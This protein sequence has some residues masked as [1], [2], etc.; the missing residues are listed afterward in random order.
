MTLNMPIL[1][2]RALQSDLR[3]DG[4]ALSLARN[5]PVP[6]RQVSVPGGHGVFIAPCPPTLDALCSDPPD[7]DRVA[8]HDS[9]GDEVVNFF[10]S[11]L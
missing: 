11:N 8:I 9:V 2:Y 7:V 10:R 4:N 6:P 3:A 5:L 1:I